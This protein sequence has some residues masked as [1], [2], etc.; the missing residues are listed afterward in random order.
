MDKGLLE[1]NRGEYL[2]QLA[3]IH[4]WKTGAEIGLW[5]GETFYHLLNSVPGIVLYGIDA[6]K[7]LVEYPHHK[8]VHENKKSIMLRALHYGDRANIISGESVK[9]A[10]LFGDGV[11]DFVFIDAD[12]SAASVQADVEAWLPKV[13]PCGYVTGHDWD[14]PSV[15]DGVNAVLT[16]VVPGTAEN[17]FVW[18]W[19]KV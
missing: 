5:Y 3:R 6:W 4:G 7:E 17:D 15:R 18:T 11:L 2:S 12:H 8:D 1:M 13:R 14:W 16:G 19:E 9:A 10:D